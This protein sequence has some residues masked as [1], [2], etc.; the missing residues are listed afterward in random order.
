MIKLSRYIYSWL[1]VIAV[2]LPLQINAT[3]AWNEGN[4]TQLEFIYKK[5]NNKE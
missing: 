4:Y 2:L 1:F 3:P 5:S